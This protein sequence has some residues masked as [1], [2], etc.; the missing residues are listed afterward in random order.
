[1]KKTNT[2]AISFLITTLFIL[3]YFICENI[4]VLPYIVL[5]KS[6]LIF[7]IREMEV[8]IL[9]FLGFMLIS[10]FAVKIATQK[11]KVKSISTIVILI[12]LAI[13]STI[14]INKQQQNIED[15][16]KVNNNN[17]MLISPANYTLNYEKIDENYFKYEISGKLQLKNGIYALQLY[18]ANSINGLLGN[19]NYSGP[20]NFINNSFVIYYCDTIIQY[21]VSGITSFQLINNITIFEPLIRVE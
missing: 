15:I 7:N 13:S 11:Q 5:D 20:I 9:F 4:G 18:K 1:M 19:C 6:N 8:P 21:K 12:V 10:L 2:L 3:V 16:T 14:L 17:I